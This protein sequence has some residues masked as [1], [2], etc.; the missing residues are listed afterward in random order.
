MSGPYS[1]PWPQPVYPQGPP[2]PVPPGNYGVPAVGPPPTHAAPPGGVGP[3]APPPGVNYQPQYPPPPWDPRQIGPMAALSSGYEPDASGGDQQ[4]A[5]QVAPDD[6]GDEALPPDRSSYDDEDDMDWNDSEGMYCDDSLWGCCQSCMPS[7]LL[8]G[9]EGVFLVPVSEPT[10]SVTMTNLLTL[11]SFSGDSDPGLGAG[12]RAWIGMQHSAG[13]GYRLRY[14]HLGNNTLRPRPAVPVNAEPALVETYYLN[15]DV[16]DFEVGPQF[17]FRDW[18]VDV[19]FGGRYARMERN[20]SVLG[21]GEVGGVDL[22]GLAMGAHEIEGVG[23]TFAIGAHRPMYLCN[24][25][26][27]N[28]LANV[29]GSVLV[30]DGTASAL[31]DA[32]AFTTTPAAAFARNEAFSSEDSF[33]TFIGEVQLGVEYHYPLCN[34][35]ALFFFRAVAEYQYWGMGNTTA[36]TGSFAFLDDGPA[37]F[38]GRVDAFSDATNTDLNLIG[39]SLGVGL[40]Y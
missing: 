16:L 15:A 40:T 13:W 2:P 34:S 36:T 25:Q 12:V 10:R 19:S 29:R 32:G 23:F 33:A 17:C 3:W 8:L 21:Y 14:T 37:T 22:Y 18:V 11:E 28:L 27:W 35:P 24:M 4:F 20:A 6:L 26:G 1:A 38:G 9:V 30:A 39:F 7:G 31:T 5:D